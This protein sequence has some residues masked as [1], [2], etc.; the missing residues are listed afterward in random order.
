MENHEEQYRGFTIELS[1]TE[2]PTIWKISVRVGTKSGDN[3]I[4]E[5]AIPPTSREFHRR[6]GAL[7]AA[8]AMTNDAKKQIDGHFTA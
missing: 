5:P 8:L 1:I 6:E 2:K 3:F 4:L 7:N